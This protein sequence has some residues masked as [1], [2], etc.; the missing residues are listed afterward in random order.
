VC[1]QELNE[2]EIPLVDQPASPGQLEQSLGQ[3][4]KTRGQ[5]SIT[6]DPTLKKGLAAPHVKLLKSLRGQRR[7]KVRRMGQSVWK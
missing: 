3:L 2:A 1:S 4:G 6:I 7:G 5:R